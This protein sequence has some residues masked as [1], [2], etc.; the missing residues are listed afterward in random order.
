[1]DAVRDHLLDERRAWVERT[2]ACADAVEECWKL[3]RVAESSQVVE[4]FRAALDRTGVLEAAPAVLAECV[5]AT[6]ERLPAQP[7]AAPPYVVVTSEGV[8]LR[9]T[10]GSDEPGEERRLVV[11]VATF[12]VERTPVGYRRGAETPEAAVAVAVRR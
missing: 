2:L 11:R 10:L 8:V 6:G 3:D 7:V 1:M 12:D 9:A 4:P 5:A